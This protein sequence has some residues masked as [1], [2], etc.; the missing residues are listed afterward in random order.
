MRR[1]I[2]VLVALVLLGGQ[3]PGFSGDLRR[4][5]ERELATDGYAT[6]DA[7]LRSLVRSERAAEEARSKAAML[8]AL[9]GVK[10]AEEDIA[11]ALATNLSGAGR[12][13]MASALLH[14]DPVKFEAVVVDIAGKVD[15][16]HRAYLAASLAEKGRF[17]LYPV[18]LEALTAGDWLTSHNALSTLVTLAKGPPPGP[19]DPDPFRVLLAQITSQ[20]RASAPVDK[21]PASTR[22]RLEAVRSVPEVL[23][24]APREERA[25]PALQ[26]LRTAADKDPASEVRE[27]A[28]KALETL[29][30]GLLTG[31]WPP[32]CSDS[33]EGLPSLLRLRG[34][35][36]DDESL[37]SLLRSRRE[38]EDDRLSAAQLLSVRGVRSAAPDLRATLLSASFLDRDL[39]VLAHALLKLDGAESVKAVVE[40]AGRLKDPALRLYLAQDL[41]QRGEPAL[42]G[43][44]LANVAKGSPVE[45]HIALAAVGALA[46]RVEQVLAPA[47][48]SIL[49]G[50]LASGQA[51]LRREAARDLAGARYTS[52]DLRLQAVQ[53]LRQAAEGDPAPEVKQDAA[54][55]LKA[56]Q[57]RFRDR[58]GPGGPRGRK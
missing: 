8:L 24:Q 50:Q 7:G 51:T 18:L 32:Y 42:Y 9:R 2:V 36:V 21:G 46:E 41:A 48:V 5:F 39:A 56:L 37:R 13:A 33:A 49:I 43:V 45:R 1:L 20:Q 11:A 54:E 47:P 26:A 14:I 35:P 22:I 34:R 17:V 58:Q 44:L 19:L 40:T 15:L 55:A 4:D 27:A 10:G 6:D 57:V 23:C 3:R 25:V 30:A 29:A 28:A 52:D 16:G 53:A 12:T 38:P 31:R